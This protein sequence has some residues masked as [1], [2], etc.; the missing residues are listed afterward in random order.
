[1]R[2]LFNAACRIAGIEPNIL[3]ESRAPHTLLA[4][5]EAEQGVAIIPSLLRT[6]RYR[7]KIVRV[8]HRRK[9]LRDRYVIQWDK[10]RPM[11]AYARAFCDALATYMRE[12]L[13][14]TR[15]SSGAVGGA[16]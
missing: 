10:R 3:L 2:C 15:P 12:V 11:P 14:I 4:L 8:T 9:P 1:V 7:L 16:S 5:V 6:D 13:P